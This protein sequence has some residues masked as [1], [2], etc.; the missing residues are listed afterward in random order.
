MATSN[1]TRIC[2]SGLR[3]PARALAAAA[4][5]SDECNH[6]RNLIISNLRQSLLKEAR[7]LKV[8]AND[9]G[10][11][12]EHGQDGKERVELIVR[13]AVSTVVQQ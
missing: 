13:G 4:I 2:G 3:I 5:T 6:G 1:V 9:T 11:E 7:F 10:S 12:Q 8:R